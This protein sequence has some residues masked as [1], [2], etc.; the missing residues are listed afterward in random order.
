MTVQANL[1]RDIALE[2]LDNRLLRIYG[3]AETTT[4]R[5]DGSRGLTIRDFRTLEGRENLAQALIMRLLTPQ[6]ELTPL[7][8][9]D[10]GAR[11]HEIIGARNTETIRNLAKLH[12][13]AAL[14]AERRIEKV[15]SV[16]VTPHVSLRQVI[17][18][19]IE[20]IP[21]GADVPLA[22]SFALDLETTGGQG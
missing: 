13:L 15:I 18:I 12:V 1:G 9:P 8:H 14:S 17:Q 20:L 10:Y 4:R 3:T 5:V 6:G 22:I 11:L 16:E 21:V 7:G 19:A 2:L